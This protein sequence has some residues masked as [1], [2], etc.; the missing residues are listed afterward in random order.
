MPRYQ[1]T[2]KDRTVEWIDGADAYQQEGQMTTFFALGDERRVVDCWSTR[3]ASFRTSEILV[4]RRRAPQGTYAPSQASDDSATI[5]PP[6]AASAARSTCGGRM[7][8]AR[9]NS[10]GNA[11]IP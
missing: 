6:M 7:S 2:L 11:L 4:I 5:P 3:L 9:V 10:S 8:T 1:V